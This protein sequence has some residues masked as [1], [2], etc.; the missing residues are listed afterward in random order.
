M[1][2]Y[3]GELLAPHQT[4]TQQARLLRR[5]LKELDGL[6][7]L[8]EVPAEGAG[9]GPSDEQ[10]RL[11]QS[12]AV[13][14]REAAKGREET[15]PAA[16]VV[17]KWDRRGPAGSPPERQSRLD[18]FLS[19]TPAP[20]QK[21][22]ADDL[23]NTVGPANFRPFA[24][25]AFGEVNADDAANASPGDRPSQAD[26]LPS[27][28]LEE[29][30][31]WVVKRRDELDREALRRRM[32][33]PR[34]LLPLKLGRLARDLR[35][36]Y[37]P[38]ADDGR[39]PRREAARAL[40][41]SAGVGAAWLVVLLLAGCLIGMAAETWLVDAPRTVASTRFCAMP[42]RRRSSRRKPSGGWRTT[43]RRP[44]TVMR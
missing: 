40:R 41:W 11:H 5:L 43:T 27:Y 32:A 39:E 18:A 33:W 4:N 10:H 15:T 22:L 16:L 7:V 23:S 24:A 30:F 17:N 1:V 35:R 29:P 25:S 3:A 26:P 37:P 21:V 12:L 8:A 28:G 31:L 44:S 13:W 2:E 14:Q 36:R 42:G 34:R 38:E 19:A 9:A 20:P 6:V